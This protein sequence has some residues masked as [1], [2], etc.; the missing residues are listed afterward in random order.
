MKD[1]RDLIDIWRI[2]NPYTRRFTFRQKTPLIQRRLDYFLISDISQENVKNVEVISAICTDHS[3]IML[4]FSNLEKYNRGSSYWKFNNALLSDTMYINSM[5]EKIDEFC[6]MNFFRDD[7]RLNWEFMKF[8][9]KEFTRK[10]SSEKKK[11]DVAK[12][13]DLERKF[14]NLSHILNA[15]SSG[16]L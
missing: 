7:P 16:G 2:R 15:N 1:S 8:K 10:Y 4:R 11:K 3:S 5:K 6:R 12:R 9:I 14:K 13:S